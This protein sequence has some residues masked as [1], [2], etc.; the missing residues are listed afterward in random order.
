MAKGL[1]TGQRSAIDRKTLGRLSFWR[2]ELA[3][4]RLHLRIL[5]ELA[6]LETKMEREEAIGEIIDLLEEV[7]DGKLLLE[8]EDNADNRRVNP[9]EGQILWSQ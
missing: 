8:K 3:M 1:G 6:R 4:Q 9:F 5:Q 2:Q 7:V